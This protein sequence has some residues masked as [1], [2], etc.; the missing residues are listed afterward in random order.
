[1][2][3]RCISAQAEVH[4]GALAPG[5]CLREGDVTIRPV[6]RAALPPAVEWL[7]D[8]KSRL[9]AQAPWLAHRAISPHR[10][11]RAGQVAAATAQA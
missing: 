10:L 7:D 3:Q 9:L 11:P 1:M 8:W 2:P 6:A 4:D 5:R